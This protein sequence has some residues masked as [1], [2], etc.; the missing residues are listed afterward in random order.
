MSLPAP[1]YQ[2][3]AVTI[4]HGDCR[5]IVPQLERGLTVTDPPYNVDYTGGTKDQLKI[6]ND[7]M[8]QEDFYNFLFSFY[9]S[10]SCQTKEGSSSYIFHA[11]LNS[12]WFVLF[13]FIILILTL[14]L[15][16]Q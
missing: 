2:D 1:Y 8:S 10:I 11:L 7:K 16:C 3:S 15:H 12:G 9:Q 14:F 6:V 5:A 4:Y 13:I